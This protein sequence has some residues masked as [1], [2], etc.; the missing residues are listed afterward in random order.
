MRL[1]EKSLFLALILALATILPS[2]TLF[3]ILAELIR[4]QAALFLRYQESLSTTVRTF[5]DEEGDDGI[6]RR[7]TD[8]ILCSLYPRENRDLWVS[9]EEAGNAGL[10]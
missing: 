8:C 9:Y 4:G 10:S 6:R 3:A 5:P 2:A 1:Q 7:S